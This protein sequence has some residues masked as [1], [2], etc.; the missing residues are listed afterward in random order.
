M[1]TLD[2]NINDSQRRL[3]R[4]WRIAARHI[5]NDIKMQGIKDEEIIPFLCQLRHPTFFTRDLGFYRRELCHARYC[6]VCLTVERNEVALYV[7]R[8][9]RHPQFDTQVKRMG[10][11]ILVSHTRMAVWRLHAVN[12][13][14]I[15]W[16]S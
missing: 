9:L 7:R 4:S 2:E 3:L 6:L 14:R 12:E 13:A 16:K 8:L 5:G 10:T 11:V 15:D 1:N